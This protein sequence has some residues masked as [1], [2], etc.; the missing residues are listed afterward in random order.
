M[1]KK[2]KLKVPQV[3]GD[4]RVSRAFKAVSYGFYLT[5]KLGHPVSR[6]F[7]K[8]LIFT[9]LFSQHLANIDGGGGTK[10]TFAPSFFSLELMLL[11][12]P[13][14]VSPSPELVIGRSMQRYED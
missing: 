12:S 5:S 4:D 13:F 6:L 2:V 10:Y 7:F 3:A 8:L 1:Y 11:D 14:P 9:H